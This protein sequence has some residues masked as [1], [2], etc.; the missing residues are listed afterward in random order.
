M[1]L[2]TSATAPSAPSF[3][4]ALFNDPYAQ[5]GCYCVMR[6]FNRGVDKVNVAD[7][8]YPSPPPA[9]RRLAEPIFE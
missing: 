7:T 4:P 2:H 6:D 9:G 1:P 3:P 8:F 5:N